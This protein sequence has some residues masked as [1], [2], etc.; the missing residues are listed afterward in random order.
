MSLE[1]TGLLRNPVIG[2]ARRTELRPGK[3]NQPDQMTVRTTVTSRSDNPESR[4]RSDLHP[5]VCKRPLKLRIVIG[6]ACFGRSGRSTQ[7]YR[8]VDISLHDLLGSQLGSSARLGR[9][10]PGIPRR[11]W[12][13]GAFLS[14]RG[15][16]QLARLGHGRDLEPRSAERIPLP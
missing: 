7:H 12:V 5:T 15:R 13:A 14:R 11:R 8:V 6:A 2:I 10:V 9:I 1:S 16:P 3:A 4:R